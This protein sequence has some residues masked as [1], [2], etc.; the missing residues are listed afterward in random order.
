MPR[1]PANTI[2]QVPSRRMPNTPQ[3]ELR[4]AAELGQ[5]ASAIGRGASIAGQAMDI[6]RRSFAAQNAAIAAEGRAGQARGEAISQL[7]RTIE[8]MGEAYDRAQ[9]RRDAEAVKEAV[10]ASKMRLSDTVYG[11]V[12]PDGARIQGTFDAPYAPPGREDAPASG[13]SV[14]TAKALQE[15]INGDEYP[16]KRL[17]PRQQKMYAEEMLP[18]FESVRRQ[19]VDVD[20]R[21]HQRHI[22]ATNKAAD[23]AAQRRLDELAGGTIGAEWVDGLVTEAN[24]WAMRTFR[25]SLQDPS[26]TNFE[27]AKW[28][29]EEAATVAEEGMRAYIRDASARRAEILID[30]AVNEVSDSSAEVYLQNALDMTEFPKTGGDP[31]LSPQQAESVKAGV[32]RARATRVSRQAAEFRRL[33]TEA[34]QAAVDY[35]LGRNPDP[36]AFHNANSQLPPERQMENRQLVID[37]AAADEIGRFRDAFDQHLAFSKDPADTRPLLTIIAAMKTDQAKADAT[38]LLNSH[39]AKAQ[40]AQQKAAVAWQEQNFEEI[41]MAVD[42]GGTYDPKTRKYISMTDE[43]MLRLALDAHKEGRIDHKQ[44]AEVKAKLAKGLDKT[45]YD[46]AMEALHM[47]LDYPQLSSMFTFRDGT[48]RLTEKGMTSSKQEF[49]V[50]ISTTWRDEEGRKRTKDRK[51]LLSTR[52]VRNAMQAYVEWRKTLRA[53]GDSKMQDSRVKLPPDQAAAFFRSLLTYESNPDIRE[54]NSIL[55]EEKLGNIAAMI[56]LYR[57]FLNNQQSAAYYE[58]NARSATP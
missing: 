12:S 28:I 43:Q 7:G 4:G 50:R 15:W 2:S 20:N 21:N 11:S 55:I 30:K 5:L 23:M 10:T 19:A 14:A 18:V 17:S 6:T 9:K 8:V 13:A 26:A 39:Q 1:V 16:A 51:V 57:T 45:A 29:S 38:L 48:V 54:L 56:R 44:F 27:Q 42:L 40:D 25:N 37:T 35:A 53:A 58:Q 32:E 34:K 41:L 36:Q 24:S 33:E 22:E 31:F 46:D 49:P 47:V 52:I 3:V